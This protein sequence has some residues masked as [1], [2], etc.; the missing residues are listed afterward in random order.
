[1]S[2]PSDSILFRPKLGLCDQIEID[3]SDNKTELSWL[4][5]GVGGS[6]AVIAACIRLCHEK[7]FGLAI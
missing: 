4:I 1:M 3:M 2:C 5:G 6:L 7:L